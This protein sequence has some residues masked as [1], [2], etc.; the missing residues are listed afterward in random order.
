MGPSTGDGSHSAMPRSPSCSREPPPVE[1]RG[2][3]EGDELK[4]GFRPLLLKEELPLPPPPVRGTVEGTNAGEGSVQPEIV[5]RSDELASA[6]RARSRGD[7]REVHPAG[8]PR[9]KVPMTCAICGSVVRKDVMSRHRETARCRRALVFTWAEIAS[10][11][12]R[13]KV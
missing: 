7:R 12:P 5:V 11:R 9:K 6:K 4:V 13:G 8:T 1:R 3:G 2:K 10:G